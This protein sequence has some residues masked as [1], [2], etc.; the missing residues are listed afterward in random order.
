MKL[1]TKARYGL[2]IMLDV[3]RHGTCDYVSMRDISQRQD[4]SLKYVEKL[5]RE[6][7]NAGFITSKLG[8]HGGYTMAL[9][10]E[11]ISV[12]DVVTAM[13]G[14]INLVDCWL[15]GSECPRH[16]DCLTCLLWAKVSAQIVETLGVTTLADLLSGGTNLC[17]ADSAFR[18]LY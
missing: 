15:K 8:A 9:A 6:L 14:R 18:E 17:E 7:K 4:I 1:S 16:A 2:R 5:L 3:A 13:E 11:N 10:A 12:G